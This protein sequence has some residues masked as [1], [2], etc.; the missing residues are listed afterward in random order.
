MDT[1]FFNKIGHVATVALEER[2]TVNSKWYTTICLSKV[3]GEIRRTNKQRRIVHH[4]CAHTFHA[5]IHFL[6]TQKI[7]LMGHSPLGPDLA[8]K[9]YFL[10]PNI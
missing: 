8:P 5:T 4:T 9:D 3:F 7:K 10:F 1:C 2:R 6:S